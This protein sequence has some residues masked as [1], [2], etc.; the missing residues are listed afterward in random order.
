MVTATSHLSKA[1]GVVVTSPSESEPI[2][3]P[4]LYAETAVPVRR[5]I[6]LPGPKDGG[7]VLVKLCEG[8]R[9]IH[10]SKPEPKAK[11]NG[12]ASEEEDSDI[13]S[14]EGEAES[15]EKVWKIGTILAEA[16]VKSIKKGG[17][18]EVMANVANDLN[19]QLTT[20]EVGGK[21]G[22]RGDVQGR[23]IENGSA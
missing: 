4:L 9:G 8:T 22:V 7:D 11:T 18:V 16:A 14:D 15:R 10:I 6:H 3:Q 13:D 20:R 19:V 23:P 12:D 1:I 17:K 2:F 5:T 21:G